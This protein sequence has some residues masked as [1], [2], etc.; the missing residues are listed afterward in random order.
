MIS[1]DHQN[2]R[3]WRCALDANLG[4]APLL[5]ALGDLAGV[6]LQHAAVLFTVL[7][8]LGPGITLSQGPVHAHLQRLLQ[9]SAGREGGGREGGAAYT[10]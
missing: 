3:L 5:G 2:T 9:V 8:V 1:L 6:S 4:Q 7:L 10:A